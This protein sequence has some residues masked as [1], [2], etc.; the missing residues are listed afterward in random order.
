MSKI[1]VL[2]ITADGKALI[3]YI[4]WHITFVRSLLGGPI[5]T[6]SLFNKSLGLTC[7]IRRIDKNAPLKQNKRVH[8]VYGDVVITSGLNGVLKDLSV[9]QYQFLIDTFCKKK[10]GENYG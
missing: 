5:D 10:E 7:Y 3:T 8:G 9:E 4:P 2:R 1:R 6:I